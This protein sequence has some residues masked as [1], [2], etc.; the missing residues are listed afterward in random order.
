MTRQGQV[1]RPAYRWII[2]G[3]AAVIV[4]LAALNIPGIWFN[5]SITQVREYCSSGLIRSSSSSCGTASTVATWLAWIGGAGIGVIVVSAVR[6]LVR[7]EWPRRGTHRD[8]EG[9]S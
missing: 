7:V 3:T 8:S 2:A 6:L 5:G 1:M 9:K 4:W